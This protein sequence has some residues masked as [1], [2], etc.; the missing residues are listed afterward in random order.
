MSIIEKIISTLFLEEITVYLPTS[1]LFLY[2][3]FYFEL[4]KKNYFLK[5]VF[6]LIPIVNIF[7]NYSFIPDYIASLGQDSFLEIDSDYAE[8]VFYIKTLFIFLFDVETS[9]RNP[10]KISKFVVGGFLTL[11]IIFKIVGKNYL[12]Q[13]YKF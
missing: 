3:F 5:A 4:K 2:F 7:Y 8:A 13:K 9:G 12:T 11:F 1:I 6:F 10:E